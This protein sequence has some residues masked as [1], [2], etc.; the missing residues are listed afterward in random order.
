MAMVSKKCTLISFA[1]F[2]AVAAIQVALAASAQAQSPGSNKV[3]AEALFESG[4]QL[5][6][7]GKYAEACPKFADSQRL[8]P[9][10]AT[11]LNLASCWEK[12][13]RAATAWATYREAQSAAHAAGRKDYM[14]T[15]ERHANALASKL[16][17]ITIHVP[18]PVEGIQIERDGVVVDRAEWEL[19]LPVDSGAHVIAAT[20]PGRKAWAS[21]IEVTQDGAAHAVTVPALDPLPVDSSPAASAP[22][23]PPTTAQAPVQPA[24]AVPQTAEASKENRASG[25]SQR[26][27]AGVVSGLGIVG[28]AV[29]AG[30]AVVAKNK[31]N[32]SLSN[33]TVLDHNLC[34][35]QGGQ[36]RGD[37][38]SAGDAATVAFGLGAAAL[39]AGGILWFTAP[40]GVADTSGR[41]AIAIAPT[42]GGAVLRATW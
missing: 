38:R 4:R 31:Y 29:S 8:D 17:R 40:R 11:L 34:N 3:T 10:I 15:A 5:V 14:A 27:V 35:T 1:A 28:L 9:S 7:E 41:A 22:A 39:A 32:D 42:I 23:P 16:A 21:T 37:A 26:V 13:G 19:A 18:Q 30:L 6:A 20:A 2:A 36:Q 33:C 24:L 12:L 25:S